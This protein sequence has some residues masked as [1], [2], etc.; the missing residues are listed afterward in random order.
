[1]P[2]YDY[3]IEATGQVIEVKHTM[4]MTPVNWGELSLLCNLD[5][6]EIPGDSAV[7]KLIS[8]AGV[9]KSKTLKNPEAPPCMTGGGC[10]G[11]GCR[12]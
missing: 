6:Q 9:V 8:A 10:P 2:S 1:M 5:P 12:I 4:A 3:R 11:G 7:T